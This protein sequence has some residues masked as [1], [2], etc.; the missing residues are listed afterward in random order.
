MKLPSD[1]FLRCIPVIK[2]HETIPNLTVST[3]NLL[4]ADTRTWCPGRLESHRDHLEMLVY[5]PLHPSHLVSSL[6][7]SSHV[8]RQP[9]HTFHFIL[10][11]PASV[12]AVLNGSTL[13]LTTVYL[14]GKITYSRRFSKYTG[15]LKWRPLH[16]N[17]G[18]DATRRQNSGKHI[19]TQH[20]STQV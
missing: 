3:L 11:Q 13:I 4:S 20:R 8:Q 19:C 7:W 10:I 12:S 2:Q 18:L 17:K 15:L 16:D 5:C 9:S 1:A 6:P 14:K